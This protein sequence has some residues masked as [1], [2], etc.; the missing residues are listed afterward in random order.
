MVVILS[1][2]GKMRAMSSKERVLTAIEHKEPDRVPID[3][4]IIKDAYVK[5]RKFLHLPEVDLSEP[6]FAPWLKDTQ[7]DIDVLEKFDIDIVRVSTRP[8]EG[9]EMKKLP[10]GYFVDEWM[11]KLEEKFYAPEI[12]GDRKSVV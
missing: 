5:L 11:V 10:D 7:V 12:G 4:W 3:M 1:R 8:P 6:G 2:R 9:R